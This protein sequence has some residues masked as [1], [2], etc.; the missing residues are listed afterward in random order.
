MT[1]T[2]KQLIITVYSIAGILVVANLI[3]TNTLATQ[4]VVVDGL[5]AQ[6]QQLQE[7][8]RLLNYEIN[9]LA[10][11]E[12]LTAK[13]QHLGFQSTKTVVIIPDSS[14]VAQLPLSLSYE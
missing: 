13:A 10:N 5:Y 12:V 2:L 9:T 4:G 8:N 14:S 3:A 1:K 11:L 6:T 7:E